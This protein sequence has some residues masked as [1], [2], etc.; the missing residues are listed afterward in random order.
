MCEVRRS[1]GSFESISV[2]DPDHVL[3]HAEPTWMTIA[4]SPHPTSYVGLVS[5]SD[6]TLPHTALT[7]TLSTRIMALKR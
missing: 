3:Q 4:T 7:A 6:P 1:V 2:G 5:S